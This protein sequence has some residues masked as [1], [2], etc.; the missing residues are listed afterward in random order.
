MLRDPLGV[1]GKVFA[2]NSGVA[3]SRW[4]LVPRLRLFIFPQQSGTHASE[5]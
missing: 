3:A 1:G 2:E 5:L 4:S